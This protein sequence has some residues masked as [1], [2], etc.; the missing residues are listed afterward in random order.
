MN[1]SI[2]KDTEYYYAGEFGFFNVI[3]LPI[4]EKYNGKKLTIHTSIIVRY[5][6][7]NFKVKSSFRMCYGY[8][9]PKREK[10]DS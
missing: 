1:N 5:P 2:N 4:L 3:L 9:C 6:L 8:P 10:G 7:S